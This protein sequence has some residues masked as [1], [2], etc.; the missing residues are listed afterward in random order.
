M[1]KL[2]HV[3]Y[4][5]VH[6]VVHSKYF[7]SHF[8]FQEYKKMIAGNKTSLTEEKILKLTEIDFVF[9]GTGHRRK[10]RHNDNSIDDG[11]TSSF[12]TMV[13]SP[14]HTGMQE[15]SLP[16]ATNAAGVSVPSSINYLGNY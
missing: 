12:N 10:R 8:H 1:K 2:Y 6:H 9:D 3:V 5:V 11:A 13:T 7:H 15:S 16:A 4:H 14:H